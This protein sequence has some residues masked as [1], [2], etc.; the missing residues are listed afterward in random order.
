MKIRM[1]VCSHVDFPGMAEVLAA[2][3]NTMASADAWEAWD[4]VCK[5]AVAEHGAVDKTAEVIVEV[6]D[7]PILAA[8]GVPTPVVAGVVSSSAVTE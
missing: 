3:E 8:L 4:E 1:L 6:A 2:W 7:A 5:R